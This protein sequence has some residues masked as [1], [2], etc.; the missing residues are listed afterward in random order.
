MDSE[1][2]YFIHALYSAASAVAI[3]SFFADTL[4]AGTMPDEDG[5]MTLEDGDSDTGGLWNGGATDYG[6]FLGTVLVQG[7]VMPVFQQITSGGGGSDT[8]TYAV[9]CPEDTTVSWPATLDPDD[10]A[11]ASDG[12]T[13][14]FCFGPGTGIATPG[15]ETAVEDLKP[16]DMVRTADGA[17]V[18]V[19]WVGVRTLFPRLFSLRHGM[20]RI[21]AHALGHD[22]PARDLLVTPDHAILLDGMMVTAGALA[23]AEGIGW[24]PRAKAPNTQKVYHVETDRHSLIYANGLPAETFMDTA[25]RRLFDNHADYVLRFGTERIVP[26]MRMPRIGS[27]RLLPPATRARL[28]LPAAQMLRQG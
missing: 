2:T 23:G 21:R 16:G 8:Y 6:L 4:V 7:I 13:F 28:G 12:A 22:R 3:A 14:A 9:L 10:V 26:E 5:D 18:P 1:F 24:E 27:A 19:R 15:G 20:I 25:G 11:L 17:V